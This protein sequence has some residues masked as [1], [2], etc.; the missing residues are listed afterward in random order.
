MSDYQ[1]KLGV[2]TT[3]LISY[4]QLDNTIEDLGVITENF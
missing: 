4:R 3:E 1:L 2:L